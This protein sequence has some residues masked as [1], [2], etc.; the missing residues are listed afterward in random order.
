MNGE[1]MSIEEQA[2]A[3]IVFQD[4]PLLRAIREGLPQG[5][6]MPPGVDICQRLQYEES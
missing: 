6:Q 4:D 2:A 1:E 5:T 3:A